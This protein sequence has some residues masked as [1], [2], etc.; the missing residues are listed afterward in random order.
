MDPTSTAAAPPST[1]FS[2][3][4]KWIAALLAFLQFAVILDFMIMSPLGALIIPALNIT[5]AQ[6]G[7]VVSAYAFSA[8]VSGLLTAGF[9]DRFDRKRLLMF[10][11]TGFIAGTFWCAVAQTFPSLLAARI[12]TG[13]FGGVI[14]SVVMAIA[15]D[16]FAPQLR[17]RVMGVIQT[18]FAASQVLGIP[19]SLYLAN[20]WEWHMPFYAMTAL[21]CVGVLM[22]ALRM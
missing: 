22:V 2:P 14:G 7:M 18:A 4:Q 10:F 11:F 15:T 21:A 13:L 19:V 1:T 8:G 9:A 5:P 17:G 16:L 6:F 20:R 12:F 3:Y